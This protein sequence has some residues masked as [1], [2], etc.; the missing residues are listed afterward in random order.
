[1][2]DNLSFNW[3]LKGQVEQQIR[4]ATKDAEKLQEVIKNLNVDLSK[5]SAEKIQQNIAKNVQE[6][7]KSLYKLLDAKEKVDKALSRNMTM[8]QDGLAGMDESKLLGISAR[9]EEIIGKVM[10]IGAEANFSA[11]AVKNLMANLSADVAL[12]EAKNATS[13]MDK[14]LDKQIKERAKAEKDAA[15]EIAS[16]FEDADKAAKNNVKNQQLVQDSLAK[17]ATARANLTAASERGNQQDTA[18]AQLLIS[19]LDRLSGKLNTLRSQFLGE[20]GALDGILGSGFTGLM[21]NVNSTISNIGKIGSSISQSPVDLLAGKGDSLQRIQQISSEMDSIKLKLRELKTE[22][23]KGIFRPK[24]VETLTSRYATLKTELDGLVTSLRAIGEASNIY[25]GLGHIRGYAGPQSALSDEAWQSLKREVEMREIATAAEEKHKQKLNELTAAFDRQARAQEN[26][27]QEQERSANAQQHATQNAHKR[28]QASAE[29]QRNLN[30]EAEEVVRLRLE[31]LKTQAVQLQGLIKNG[32]GLLDTAQI[33]QYRNAL[34]DIIREITT[35]KGVMSNIDSFTGRNSIGLMAFGNGANYS[36]LISHGQQA[37][38]A[39][40]AVQQLTDSERRFVESISQATTALRL[41]GYVIS[42][43]ESIAQRYLSIWGAK[44][45]LDN[46]IETGGLLEQQRLSIGAI[47]GDI[48][49]ANELFGKIKALALQSPF[50]VVEL[51]RMS[52]QLTAFGFKYEELYDWTKRLADISAATG[53]GVDRLAL[54]LGHVRNEVALSGYTLRQFAMANVPMAGKLAEMKG[55]SVKEIRAMVKKKQISD[56]DVEAVL[57]S[58]TDKGGMFYNA[59]ETMAQALNAK[60]KNLRDAFDIMY[61]E[62]AESGVG[63]LLKKL[64]ETLTVGAKQW[65]R[66]GTDILSVAAAFTII[67]GAVLVYNSAIGLGTAATLKS[68]SAA[69]AK[70]VANLKLAQ[71]YRQ[72]TA[73]ESLSLASKGRLSSADLAVLLSEKKLTMAELQRMVAL[74][75]VTK[76][77]AIRAVNLANLKNQQLQLNAAELQGVKVLNAWQAAGLRFKTVINGMKVAVGSFI[78]TFWPM[79]AIGAV[80]DV[81]AKRNH[82]EEEANSAGESM[83]DKAMS[84]QLELIKMREKLDSESPKTA[85]SLNESIASITESLKAHGKYN[86]ELRVQ[87]EMTSKLT[88]KYALLKAELD[89]VTDSYSN[90]YEIVKNGLAAAM[91]VKYKNVLGFNSYFGDNMQTLFADLDKYHTKMNAYRAS[92][93]GQGIDVRTYLWDMAK[94]GDFIWKDD[95]NT[96]NWT[97]IYDKLSEAE[98]ENIKKHL[99]TWVEQL[100]EADRDPKTYQGVLD[101]ISEYEEKGSDYKNVENK[102]KAGWSEYQEMVIGTF[103][104][105]NG[106]ADLRNMSQEEEQLLAKDIHDAKNGLEGYSQWLKNWWESNLLHNLGIKPYIEEGKPDGLDG[107]LGEL[108]KYLDEH[109]IKVTLSADDDVQSVQKKMKEHYDELK[110]KMKSYGNILIPIGIDINNLPTSIDDILDKK[111]ISGPYRDWLKQTFEDALSASREKKA[112]EQAEK[113]MPGITQKPEKDKKTQTDKWLKDKREQL[114]EIENFYKIY[115]RNSEYMAND[116]AIQKALDSGVFSNPKKLPKNIDDYLKVLQDFRKKVEKEIGKKPS[117]ERKSFLTDLITK[118]D[119]KEFEVKT[120]QVA[121]AALK[122]LDSE[123]KK[124]GKQ[125]NLYKKILDATGNKEQA[126]QI[127]FGGAVRFDNYAEQLREEISKALEG[128]KKASGVSIDTLLGLDEKQLKDDYDI[129]G[130]VVHKLKELEEVEQ[131]LKS[132]DVELFLDA[133]KNAKSLETELDQITLKYDKTRKAI[134]ANGGDASLLQNADENEAREKADKQW[135]WFKKTNTE[136]GRVFGNLDKMTIKTLKD[137]KSQLL[138]LAP[139]LSESVEST[140]ALYE[141]I[142]KID[143][144]VNKRNPFKAMGEAI[145]NAG[146]IR[147]LIRSGINGVGFRNSNGTYTIGDEQARKLGL[148]VNKK[149]VYSEKELLDALRGTETDFNTAMQGVVS[150][151]KDVQDALT[152]VIDLFNAL[153]MTELG[154]FFSI[155]GNALGAAAQMSQGATALFGA[156]AGPWGAA[157]GAGLSVMTS[158]FS[159]HD[160]ALQE[161]IDASKARQKEMEN[162][163]KNLEKALERTLGGVYRTKASSDDIN[164]LLKYRKLYDRAQTKKGIAWLTGTDYINDDTASAIDKALGTESYYDTKRAEMLIQRDELQKQLDAEES[165]KDSSASAIEDY[166]QQIKEMEDDLENFA[167]DMAKT[168]YDIDIKSWASELGDALYE[169]WQKGEDGAEAFK[170]KASELI[171]QVAKKII[172]VSILEAALEPVKKII[173]QMMDEGSGQ[174]DPVKF[175]EKIS[176]A[177]EESLGTIGNT[178][179]V[180]M[181]AVDAALQKHGYDSLKDSSSDTSSN[182]IKGVTEQTADLIASYLNAIRL[183]VSVNRTT[184]Q[185]ILDA[186]LVESAGGNARNVRRAA[187]TDVGDAQ[188]YAA[189]AGLTSELSGIA[190]AQLAQLMLIA[191]NTGRNAGLVQEVRDIMHRVTMGGDAI[192]VK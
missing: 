71:S 74:K 163:T 159:M 49:K 142:E 153:G 121:D 166:K 136:W 185:N 37:L 39:S 139:S 7:E 115:K 20:K 131:Q 150:K 22:E 96:S 65:Q 118:I 105:K 18:H 158:I 125:W 135:E 73:E 133:I 92:V 146:N 104:E 181:N 27:R 79:L 109:K 43:I 179:E 63:D 26:E 99:E 32:K 15:K 183:D 47:L 94:H 160:K 171:G 31:M 30:K 82:Q 149:G 188:Q 9:L 97:D 174:L 100:K 110:T 3:E 86:D 180:T 76:E 145:S 108:Q 44:A 11:N 130:E 54:A 117:A 102:I 164:R 128:N 19:L 51:D 21:R 144:V 103:M 148:T 151:F 40:R 5:L 14:G 6:A 8:R 147:G 42:D 162:L 69:K 175:A 132:E 25:G 41:Q 184:L 90:Q 16:A 152:P 178:Y 66:F 29:T 182:T 87:V 127:A 156:S 168:L 83:A 116:D 154:N 161:E 95:Y 88:E 190:Q 4:N 120:K 123:L 140:K 113:E 78:R 89:N 126:S 165:K 186:L 91:D 177:L 111:G 23:E 192:K 77:E 46:I 67:K 167:M 53:T 93:L 101:V 60:F 155:G 2:A 138:G 119:E 10:N 55:V 62:I 64:A 187:A 137:M 48:D 122:K 33:E 112:V 80:M 176:T 1:M 17:I 85:A 70:E 172:S 169:A 36:P 106:I 170:K 12:K 13:F 98:R 52:K 143:N 114:K 24:D 58:L 34:R 81:I 84:R 56:K 45:F 68:A 28:A 134:K 141:A 124:Q 75:Y 191:K 189:A 57:K 61:G 129:F 38:E 59:Q 107:W 173:A 157:I 50:G 72:L 35:L